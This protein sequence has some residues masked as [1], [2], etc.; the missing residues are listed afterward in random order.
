M[1]PSTSLRSRP[2]IGVPTMMSCN[3][4]Y[5]CS[6]TFIAPTTIINSVTPARW[7]SPLTSSLNPWLNLSTNLPP[8]CPPCPLSPSDTP[9]PPPTRR[10]PNSISGNSPPNCCR[11]YL[12]SSSS[13][14]P[15]SHSRCHTA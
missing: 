12:T 14:S 11:Q 10:R 7:L 15:L 9:P 8:R 5:L 4:V 3:P 13:T 2:A 6:S 1:S